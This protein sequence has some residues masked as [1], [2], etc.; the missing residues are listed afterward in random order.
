MITQSHSVLISQGEME[1]LA[2]ISTTYCIR[3]GTTPGRMRES[4][5][6]FTVTPG[7]H[8]TKVMCVLG[9]VPYYTHFWKVKLYFK[10][11]KVG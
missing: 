9:R 2:K 3:K 1:N 11:H 8:A 4:P 6:S 10:F 5:L 7:M